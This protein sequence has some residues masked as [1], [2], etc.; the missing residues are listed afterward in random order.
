[1]LFL[2]AR[3][4]WTTTCFQSRLPTRARYGTA[5]MQLSR[6]SIFATHRRSH[7][8]ALK[9]GDINLTIAKETRLDDAIA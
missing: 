3:F 7:A 6:L 9:L 1:M 4:E 8:I 2:V 5:L